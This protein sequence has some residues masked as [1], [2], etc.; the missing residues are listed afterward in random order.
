MSL[1]ELRCFHAVAE[2]GSFSGA[3]QRLGR[4][5][6]TV[7]IQIAQ[8]EKRYGIELLER[9]RG[10]TLR[11]TPLGQQ[12]F[13]LT[14][15][16]FALETD[17]LDLLEHG[18]TLASGQL[19]IG[20][21][22]PV[23]PTGF[24]RPFRAAYPQIDVSLTL[25]NSRSVYDDVKAFRVDV[26]FLGGAGPFP[27]CHSVPLGHPEIVLVCARTHPL[28]DQQEISPAAL[29]GETLL[30]R[31]DG[32]ETR[33]LFLRELDA[34]GIVPEKT[35]EI[36][37]REGVSAAASAGLGLAIISRDEIAEGFDL[38]ILRLKGL[39]ITG[40]TQL[41]CRSERRDKRVIK[42]FLDMIAQQ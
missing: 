22:S 17:A 11:V 26:G 42:A 39:T 4:A 9:Q 33:A 10:K 40:Q 21:S 2:S 24:I 3:A 1:S 6:P 15:P 38:E 29:A 16:L 31:E 32:S 14:R 25:G 36:G 8:L 28:A 19:K 20:A 34:A 41:I 27:G 35:I 18:S 13:M 30:L 23:L 37:S 5:Q 7:T 12:L